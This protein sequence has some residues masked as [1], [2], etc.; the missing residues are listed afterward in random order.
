MAKQ[1]LLVEGNDDKHVFYALLN[2]HFSPTP[3]MIIADTG[4]IEKLLEELP[5]WLKQSDL[6]QLGVVVDADTMDASR[7][8]N[9]IRDILL[10]SKYLQLPSEL[11]PEGVIVKQDGKPDVGIWI[12][13]DNRLPGMLED[14]VS[15]LVNDGDELWPLSQQAVQ[16]IPQHLRRFID[17]HL[18]KAKIHTWLAWQEDT[19]TPL[20]LAITKRYLNADAPPASRLMNWVRLLFG[21]DSQSN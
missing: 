8:W 2:H 12:M 16:S 18:S 6:R 14:F 21:L 9:Q 11:S 20:G 10:R 17:N 4:G 3:E 15:F 1:L 5:V 7:R 19:G 13:P